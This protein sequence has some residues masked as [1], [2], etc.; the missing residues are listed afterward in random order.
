[1]CLLY[2]VSQSG[3]AL[4]YCRL[5]VNVPILR[6][7][8]DVESELIQDFRLSRKAVH[9]LQRLLRRE[10]EHGWGYELEVLIY[11]YWL[12]HGLSYRVVSRVF[13]IPK[14]TVHR[15]I[16]KVAQVIWD[17]LHSAISFPSH[18]NLDNVG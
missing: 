8:F 10:Q 5:N 7:W 3:C 13:S 6:L 12:A 18:A 4:T 1:M 9:A 14:S 11:V 15:I 2:I 16:H 17:N